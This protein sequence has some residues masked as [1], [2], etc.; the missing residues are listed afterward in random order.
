[1][2]ESQDGSVEPKCEPDSPTSSTTPHN[3]TNNLC[4]TL[5][6]NLPHNIQ[7]NFNNSLPHNITNNLSHST[8][9]NPDKQ[10][11]LKD[12]SYKNGDSYNTNNINNKANKTT[13]IKNVDKDELHNSIN[14]NNNINTNSNNNKS[15]KNNQQVEKQ[16]KN[17]NFGTF[18]FGK[19]PDFGSSNFAAYNTHSFYPREDFY[20]RFPPSLHHNLYHQQNHLF[21][22]LGHDAFKRN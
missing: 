11:K 20:S 10:T 12:I 1:M 5:P 15:K 17:N 2:D 22:T 3:L 4:H 8:T 13:M 18:E 19:F 21:K 7:N 14:C 6:H 16:T 9:T